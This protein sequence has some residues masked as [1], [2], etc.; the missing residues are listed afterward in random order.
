M[1]SFLKKKTKKHIEKS[2]D[3]YSSILSED[4]NLSIRF[5]YRGVIY[6]S[7]VEKID[8]SEII[9]RSPGGDFTRIDLKL[10]TLMNINLISN[11]ELYTTEIMIKEKIVEDNSVYYKGE[12]KGLIDQSKRR[13]HYRLPIKLNLEFYLLQRPNIKYEGCTVD[14]SPDGMLLESF[15]ELMINKDIV[16]EI[17]IENKLYS[18]DGNILRRRPNYKN[19]AFLYNIKFDDVSTRHKKELAS[20]IAYKKSELENQKQNSVR[21]K[22]D[23]TK[24]E[25]NDS[26]ITID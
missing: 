22:V 7:Y 10:N 14:I 5:K 26:E 16:I 13:K 19:G 15:E 4:I 20:F 18:L 17:N 2:I 6:T 24:I 9:F 11:N 12:I 25:V 3:K 21:K 8:N 1:L 23:N